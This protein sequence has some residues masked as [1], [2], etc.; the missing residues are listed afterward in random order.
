MTRTQEIAAIAAQVWDQ[1]E[2]SKEDLRLLEDIS[3]IDRWC[4]K[5]LSTSNWT[6]ML[7]R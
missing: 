3:L 5:E 6:L 4:S 1:D 7:S 2:H